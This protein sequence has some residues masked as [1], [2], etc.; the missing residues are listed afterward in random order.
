MKNGLNRLFRFCLLLFFVGA[1]GL[2]WLFVQHNPF[3]VAMATI[4]QQQTVSEKPKA[5]QV[6]TQRV[7]VVVSASSS[8]A[9]VI[10]LSGEVSAA[11]KDLIRLQSRMGRDGTLQV[12][13]SE[14]QVTDLFWGGMDLQLE[15]LLPAAECESVGIE[16]A[17]G[18]IR[19]DRLSAKRA[20][21]HSSTGDVQ[22]AG[23]TG[24]G[25]E[26]GTDTGD[27]KLERVTAAL[28]VR[29]STGDVDV[30][31][32]PE[33]LHDLRIET[34]TGDVRVTVDDP[35]QAARVQLESDT[36]E[37]R[38]DWPERARNSGPAFT[39]ATATGDIW[40]Q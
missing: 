9:V 19:T 21:I 11:G 38:L 4:E 10:R 26:L 37:V 28:R 24:K 39:V 23:F 40:V 5:L 13:V 25:L 32:I 18:H 31:H 1:C 6:A 34:D 3:E 14:P 35:P 15:V 27:I 12:E 29:S 36:G 20:S 2:V 16:T 17:T 30:L 22:V 33:L 8:D 7:N